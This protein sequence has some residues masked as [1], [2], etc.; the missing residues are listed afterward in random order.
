MLKVCKKVLII[1]LIIIMEIISFSS[2]II[3]KFWSKYNR[4]II[5]AFNEFHEALRRELA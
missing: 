4:D 3:S 1:L 5:K 2:K